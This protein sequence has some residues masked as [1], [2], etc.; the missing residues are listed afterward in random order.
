MLI[1]GA[2]GL[3]PRVLRFEGRT[4]WVQTMAPGKKNPHPALPLSTGRGDKKSIWS[5][6]V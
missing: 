3:V 6:H 1:C 4:V 2:R 5:G